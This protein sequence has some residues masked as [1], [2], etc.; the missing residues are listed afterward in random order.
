MP[1]LL[2][3]L[4]KGGVVTTAARALR[5]LHSPLSRRRLVRIVTRGAAESA[6]RSLE[7]SRSSKPVARAH[8]FEL[9]VIPG[10][11][12]VIEVHREVAQWLAGTVGK[13][14]PAET[15]QRGWQRRTGRL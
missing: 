14:A 9:V 2:D 4:L 15:H 13:R 11:R 7:A 3:A 10:A 12:S 8:D 1:P 6:A 5:L